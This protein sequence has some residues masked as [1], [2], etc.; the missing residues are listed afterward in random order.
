MI[1]ACPGQSQGFR[2]FGNTQPMV[3]SDNSGQGSDNTQGEP[4]HRRH[5]IGIRQNLQPWFGDLSFVHLT[6]PEI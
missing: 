1:P 3:A 6:K 2:G 4:Y 5:L